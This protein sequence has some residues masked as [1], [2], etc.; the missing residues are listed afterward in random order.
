MYE[1]EDVL[2]MTCKFPYLLSIFNNSSDKPFPKKAWSLLAEKS[3]NGNTAMVGILF[4]ESVIANA[5]FALRLK[6]PKHRCVLD[7]SANEELPTIWRER[8]GLQK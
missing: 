2:E 6:D 4:C 3:L 5:D 7:Y 8:A 1:N